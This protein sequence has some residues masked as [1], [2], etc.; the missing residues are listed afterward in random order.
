MNTIIGGL[1]SKT[2]WASVAAILLPALSDG[3]QQWV[4]A[5]PGTAGAVVGATFAFLR[6][7]TTSSLANKA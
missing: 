5:H 1:K 7:V 2:M 4:A 6:M 3:V